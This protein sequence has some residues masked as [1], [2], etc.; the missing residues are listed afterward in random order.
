MTTREL[1]GSILK[2]AYEAWRAHGTF[3]VIL[4]SDEVASK[5]GAEPRE[6]SREVDYLARKDLVRDLTTG[7]AAAFMPT[8]LGV[9]FIEGPQNFPNLQQSIVVNVQ[10]NM[11]MIGSAIGS[12]NVV[13]A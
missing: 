5:I 7:S 10:G 1:R 13:A 8:V 11:T 3:N 6:A 2:E 12:K 9:D 4:S